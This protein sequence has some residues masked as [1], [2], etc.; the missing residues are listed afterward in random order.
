MRGSG[1]V[2]ALTLSAA[3]GTRGSNE[4]ELPPL[5]ASEELDVLEAVVRHQ[6]ARDTGRSKPERFLLSISLGEEHWKDPPVELL[7]RFQGHVP[8]VEP[9]SVAG[10]E[11]QVGVHGDP[12]TP[13]VVLR[14]TAIRRLGEDSVEVDGDYFSTDRATSDRYRLERRVGRWKVVND[15]IRGIY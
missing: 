1:L 2:L 9:V 4:S 15:G 13:G 6:V 5:S 14:L 11:P 12:R 10:G 3:C 8:P 7:A